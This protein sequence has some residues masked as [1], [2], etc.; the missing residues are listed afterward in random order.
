VVVGLGNNKER[1]RVSWAKESLVA[2]PSEVT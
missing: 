1:G 2:V